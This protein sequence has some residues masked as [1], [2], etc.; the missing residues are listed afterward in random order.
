[1]RTFRPKLAVCLYHQ[2]S[3][4]VRIP[5]YLEGLGLGYSF[6]LGHVTRYHEETVLFA[7][8]HA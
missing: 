7:L 6:Y 4:F 3:D 5:A 1:L 2:M 8:P